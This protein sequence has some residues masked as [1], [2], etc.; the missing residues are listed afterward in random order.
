MLE[1]MQIELD[2]NPPQL[3]HALAYDTYVAKRLTAFQRMVVHQVIA[4]RA[5][6][7]PKL[8]RLL[9][10]LQHEAASWEAPKVRYNVNRELEVEDTETGNWNP[11]NNDK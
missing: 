11:L 3:R 8:K 2:Y 7:S 1:K 6:P 10:V 9:V 4:G 5:K